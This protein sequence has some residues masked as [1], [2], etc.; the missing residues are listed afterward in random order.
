[1]K[2]QDYQPMLR[3]IQIINARLPGYLNLQQLQINNQG[4]IEAIIPQSEKELSHESDKI[5]DVQGDWISLGGVDL[6]ING[7]LGLAFPDLD[8]HH[9]PLLEKIGQFLWQQGVDAFL[10][11]IVTTSIENI[12]RSLSVIE[13]FLT[14]QKSF[15]EPTAKVLGVHLEGP[16]LNLEKRGAHPAQYLLKPTLENVNQVL[17]KNPELIKIIT[18]APEL[19]LS[20]EIIPYLTSLG[21]TVS[22]GHSQATESEAEKAFALGASMITHAFNAMPPLHHRQPGLLAA[23]IRNSQ[24]YCGFIA[25]GQHVSPSMLDIFLRANY[26]EKGAF[27]VSDALAPMG[28]VDGIYPWDERQIEVKQGTARLSDGT[29]SGTTLPLLAGVDNLLEWGI[30]SPESAIALATESPRQAIA[31][32]GLSIGKEANLLR[33]H[34]DQVSPKLVFERLV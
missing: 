1:M 23:A 15:T 4:K 5:I 3:N 16:F 14:A 34:G 24:V 29:L 28:L 32:Q 26:A 17:G 19:D 27:L 30:V 6:Q 31:L 22:L 21:I 20:N 33:W 13:S 8:Y 9:L 10:P 7:G 11:T 18:L 12:Q 2:K 25:D